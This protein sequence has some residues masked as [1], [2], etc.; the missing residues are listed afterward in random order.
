VCQK[1]KVGGAKIVDKFNSAKETSTPREEG[2]GQRHS[3]VI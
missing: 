3:A 1:A 2:L